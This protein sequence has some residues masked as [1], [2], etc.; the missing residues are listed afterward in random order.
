MKY[1]ALGLQIPGVVLLYIASIQIPWSMQTWSGK[2]KREQAF[3]KRQFVF[4]VV[5][6]VLLIVGM[7]LYW[8]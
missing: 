6:L 8:F 2:T 1:L 7:V 4:G 3:K 5:G